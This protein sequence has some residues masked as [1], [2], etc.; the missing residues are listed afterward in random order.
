MGGR[1]ILLYPNPEK[2]DTILDA[3]S[4]PG[5]KTTYLA[6]MIENAGM[7][8]AMKGSTMEILKI[9][10]DITETNDNNGVAIALEKYVL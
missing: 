6:E 2:N 4:S 3:C 9:A 7:G 1:W 10:R 5:G 8:I